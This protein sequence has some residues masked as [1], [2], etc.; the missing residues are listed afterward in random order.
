M[1][2]IQAIV[3]RTFLKKV[4][5]EKLQRIDECILSF[6]KDG[7]HITAMS[8]SKFSFVS[9]FLERKAF[10]SYEDIGMIAVGDFENFVG[11]LTHLSASV[12][13][14]RHGH[15]FSMSDATKSVDVE[16]LEESVMEKPKFPNIK[17]DGI[18]PFKMS[19]ERLHAIIDDASLN[20]DTVITIKS[21]GEQIIFSNTGRYK[22]THV[23]DAP[24]NKSNES[25]SFG[26]PLVHASSNL[27]GELEVYMKSDYPMMI[28]EASE[29]SVVKIIVSPRA[30][31]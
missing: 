22:F 9:G 2:R 11:L 7:L 23:L 13:L 19:A 1:V 3:L 28:V 4:K 24:G 29:K 10:E 27:D 8:Q 14:A 6:E 30:D 31:D 12:S 18:T 5:M 15:L 17:Y 21:V 26:V 16:L 20:K 25:C